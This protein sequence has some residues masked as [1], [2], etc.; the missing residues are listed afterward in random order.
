M[1]PRSSE[2]TPQDE[3]FRNRLENLIDQRH[4]LVH[5]AAL[6]DWE[7]FDRHL[8]IYRRL[9]QPP[10]QTLC[11]GLPFPHQLRKEVLLPARI[12]KH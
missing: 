1:G 11:A 4:E 2:P 7:D 6:I 10:S 8:R 12:G 5:L 9:V 3:L